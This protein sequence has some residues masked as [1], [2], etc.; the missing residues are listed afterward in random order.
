MKTKCPQC[1]SS[2]VTAQSKGKFLLKAALCAIIIVTCVLLLYVSIKPNEK[3]NPQ[4]IL[5]IVFNTFLILLAVMYG[6]FYL[7][8]GMLQKETTYKCEYCNNVFTLTKS[9]KQL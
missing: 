6:L 1:Q 8:K 3:G 9:D 2:N 5:H 7:G 4:Q